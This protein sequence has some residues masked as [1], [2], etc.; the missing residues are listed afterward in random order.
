M[1][2]DIVIGPDG[3]VRHV[4]TTGGALLGE[5]ARACIEHRLAGAE[6][7]PPY[8]GGTLTIH[9]PIALEGSAPEK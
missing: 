9:V 1:T 6:F 2:A 4:E 7:A 5:R 3:H 8:G